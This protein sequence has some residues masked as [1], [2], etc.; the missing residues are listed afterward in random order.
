ML[1][2]I[3]GKPLKAGLLL[4][5]ST[6]FE[7]FSHFPR[8]F[9]YGWWF[10]WFH[11][12]RFYGV[13]HFVLVGKLSSSAVVCKLLFLFQNI[14]MISGAPKC[15]PARVKFSVGVIQTN[16]SVE[17]LVALQIASDHLN[18]SLLPLD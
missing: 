7:H 9:R 3:D 12:K 15:M 8:R 6:V 5:G 18:W 2:F 10:L 13:I 16:P 11:V 17:L 4:R 1:I 14:M